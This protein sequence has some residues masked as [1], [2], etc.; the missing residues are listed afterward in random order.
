MTTA[1]VG[2]LDT[3]VFVADEANRPLDRSALPEL[4]VVS[5]ITVGELRAGVLAA[6]DTRV[7][8][9]RLATFEGVL[10]IEQLSV[11]AAVASVWAALRVQVAQAGRRI[12]VNDLWIAATAVAHDLPLYSQDTDYEILAGL[13]GP[14]FIAV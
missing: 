9:I 11:D 3:S 8:A 10:Q 6:R 5:V 1:A 14:A 7:R 12:N 4:G 13:G 2:L